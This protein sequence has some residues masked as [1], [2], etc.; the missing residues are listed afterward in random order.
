MVHYGEAKEVLKLRK[1]VLYAA[2]EVHPER[3]VH[4]EPSPQPLPKAA[5]INPPQEATTIENYSKFS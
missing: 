4:N 5:W 1:K 2:Y 3:F